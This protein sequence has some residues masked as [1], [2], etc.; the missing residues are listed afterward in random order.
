MDVSWW[1]FYRNERRE[2]SLPLQQFNAPL[3]SSLRG[4][5]RCSFYSLFRLPPLVGTSEGFWWRKWQGRLGLHRGRGYS[6][7]RQSCPVCSVWA[8]PGYAAWQHLR[9]RAGWAGRRRADKGWRAR[10][11]KQTGVSRVEWSRRGPR[12]RKKQLLAKPPLEV[13]LVES[14][15][16]PAP[17]S[18]RRSRVL[19]D[20]PGRPF[21]CG[22]ESEM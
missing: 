22:G 9:Q 3:G 4:K 18:G 1:S 7:D 17:H 12:G 11:I 20:W 10:R 2:G 8:T 13:T 14:A 19:K 21:L 15:L 16:G 6:G 5:S